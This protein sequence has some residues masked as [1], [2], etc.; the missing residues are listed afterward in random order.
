MPRFLCFFI[1]NDDTVGSFERL[2]LEQEAEAIRRVGEMLQGRTL[3]VSAEIW[4]GGQFVA[5][6]PRDR[7]KSR[8]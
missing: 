2:E 6:I 4:A 7:E 8:T 5:R 1:N 3:A